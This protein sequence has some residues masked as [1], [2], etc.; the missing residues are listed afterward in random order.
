M[1]MNGLVML[2]NWSGSRTIL[3]LSI[4]PRM[5]FGD[6]QGDRWQD[7]WES[8]PSGV[9]ARAAPMLFQAL[10]YSWIKANTIIFT[11]TPRKKC[12]FLFFLN[13]RKEIKLNIRHLKT[14]ILLT[15]RC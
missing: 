11:G 14:I 5:I 3:L 15:F 1:V 8:I 13:E 7:I 2:D 10:S 4:Q 12:I 9:L 6:L